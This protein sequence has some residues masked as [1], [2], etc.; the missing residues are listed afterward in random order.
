MG[1]RFTGLD[2]NQLEPTV[3]AKFY[4]DDGLLASH[5]A[6]RIKQGLDKFTELFLRLGLKMNATKTVVM[7]SGGPKEY[8]R[9]GPEAYERKVT[10]RGKTHRERMAGQ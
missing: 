3:T 6:K 1:P 9:Q 7:V 5:D 4:A 2:D 8:G 10:G